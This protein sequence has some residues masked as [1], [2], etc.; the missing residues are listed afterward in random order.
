MKCNHRSRV[1][2]SLT[3]LSIQFSSYNVFYLSRFCNIWSFEIKKPCKLNQ[4]TDHGLTLYITPLPPSSLYTRYIN[5]SRHR[6][7]ETT[8]QKLHYLDPVKYVISSGI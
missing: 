7:E 4:G 3:K 6:N 5:W 8:P 1:P 2:E